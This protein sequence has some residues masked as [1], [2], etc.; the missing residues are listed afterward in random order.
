MLLAVMCY[1]TQCDGQKISVRNSNVTRLRMQ[2]NVSRR[3]EMTVLYRYCCG[4][5]GHSSSKL[6]KEVMR[7]STNLVGNGEWLSWHTLLL[8]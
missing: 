4:V 7:K 5:H 8:D 1:H 6:L 3:L 2:R